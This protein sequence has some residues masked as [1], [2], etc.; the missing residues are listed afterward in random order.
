MAKG[1]D[2]A[3]RVRSTYERT[4]EPGETVFDTGESGENLFV[5]QAGEIEITRE[6]PGGRRTVAR[7]GPGDFFGEVSVVAGRP[8]SSRAVAVRSTRVLELDRSTL[9]SMCLGQPE[10]ALRMIRIL[11]ARLVEAEGR[12]AALGV[13]D[14][15]RPVVRTLVRDAQPVEKGEG[16]RVTT[17]LRR[18]AQD[19]GLSMLEAHRALHQLLDRKLCAV[20]DDALIVPDLEALSAALDT[21]D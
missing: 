11:V 7:L 6:G 4:L 19:A 15:L 8:R 17:T 2:T 20:L 3:F 9:E 14:L 10:I 1:E 5:I 21:A 12:L 13:D 18:L 16:F